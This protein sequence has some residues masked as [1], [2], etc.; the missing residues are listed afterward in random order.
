M[1][2]GSHQYDDVKADIQAWLPKMKPGAIM[3]GD[4]W[5]WSGVH[6]AATEIFGMEKIKVHLS[7]RHVRKGNP[8]K[9]RYWSVQV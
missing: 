5:N 3:S 4:D 1:I 2:D 8:N 7:E 6:D 9:C